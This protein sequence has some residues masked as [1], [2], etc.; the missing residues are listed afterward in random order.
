MTLAFSCWPRNHPEG[1][2]DK[3]Q[4]AVCTGLVTGALGVL[5]CGGGRDAPR[6]GVRV[7]ASRGPTQGPA[8][9]S[10]QTACPSLSC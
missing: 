8:G 7:A 3:L 6:G 2:L 4:N 1:T 5:V 10:A 9:R